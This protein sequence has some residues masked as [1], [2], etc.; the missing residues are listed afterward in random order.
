MNTTEEYKDIDI[1]EKLEIKMNEKSI[2]KYNESAPGD[3]KEN[4][5]RKDLRKENT[6]TKVQDVLTVSEKNSPLDPLVAECVAAQLVVVPHLMNEA[7]L[8]GAVT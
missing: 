6:D 1:Q 8:V 2:D 7:P 3:N 5:D 4:L